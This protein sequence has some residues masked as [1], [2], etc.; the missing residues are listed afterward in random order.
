MSHID[1]IKR[2]ATNWKSLFKSNMDPYV[3]FEIATKLKYPKM[4]LSLTTSTTFDYLCDNFI[5]FGH[6]RLMFWVEVG[7]RVGIGLSLTRSF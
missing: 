3:R 2:A 1:R 7:F 5:G 6:R 4:D